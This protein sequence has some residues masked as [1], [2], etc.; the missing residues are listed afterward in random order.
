M[1]GT[2]RFA[3]R[4]SGISEKL[5]GAAPTV[6]LGLIVFGTVLLLARGHSVHAQ[7]LPLPPD[8]QEAVN[9]AIDRGVAY[10]KNIQ[11]KNGT[12][13]LPKG[14][15]AVGYAALPGLT[16]LECGVPASDPVIQRTAQFL[17][18][19]AA[20]LDGTYE[21][22]LAILFLDRLGCPD[23]DDKKLLQ[24]FALR[25]IAGQSPTGG[26][27]YKCP[28]LSKG[29][30]MELMTA[31]RHLDP[32]SP[33]D[34]PFVAGDPSQKSDK[35]TEMR[36]LSL[37]P[38]RSGS[39]CPSLWRDW[40]G[41]SKV[42]VSIDLPDPMPDRDK[43]EEDASPK[44]EPKDGKLEEDRADAKFV[45]K[46]T[47]PYVI[48]ER[49]RMFTVIQDP[50]RHLSPG[51]DER[52]AN[53]LGAATD[54]S[55]TQF[56]ILALWTA[57]RHEV[58]MKRTL[59]LIVRRFVTSQ[60][61]DGSWG[62]HFRYGGDSWLRPDTMTCVGLIGLAVGHGLANPAVGKPVRDPRILN[63]LAALSRNLGEPVEQPERLPMQNLY[64]LW[65]VERVAVLYN[66]PKI[67]NKDWY[68]WGVQVLI[69]NQRGGD[70]WS[71]GQYP[72]HSP[73]LDTCLALLFLKRA[74]LVKDLT[75]K[76]PFTPT[77]LNN[78]VLEKLAPPPSPPT[79]PE[80]IEKPTRPSE[81]RQPDNLITKPIGQFGGSTATPTRAS[82]VDSERTCDC[83]KKWIALSLVLFVI[84]TGGSLFF[85]LVVANQTRDEDEDELR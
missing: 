39:N 10:L 16:L 74:N 35:G 79:T 72:G 58:P 53:L 21:L 34:M 15:Y 40:L 48:P 22:S 11:Q 7:R 29:A 42:D 37:P 18:N 59:N 52:V 66:L 13:A 1:L 49:L 6:R 51:M 33:E 41:F 60:N 38:R 63:G 14:P 56:A 47:K 43:P 85:F 80:P 24:M 54:N 23:P 45:S 17:R 31:L 2:K 32:S 28:I 20:K 78:G 61:D 3:L 4:R 83:K 68:R 71:N 70:H 9:H 27:G 77:D 44:D 19:H 5:Q 84:L 26:W 67:G 30:Q 36:R 76:L 55:N 73:P 57:R 82:E 69:A 65:S 75:A 25:L 46:S 50:D 64:F 8:E 12:W 62:Y 81:P